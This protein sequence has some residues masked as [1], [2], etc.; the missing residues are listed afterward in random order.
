MLEFMYFTVKQFISVCLWNSSPRWWIRH[1]M[2]SV[3]KNWQTPIRVSLYKHIESQNCIRRKGFLETVPS[4][5]LNFEYLQGQ[6]SHSSG[7]SPSCNDLSKMMERDLTMT[8]NSSMSTLGCF[9][10]GPMDLC[11]FNWLKSF[12]S[13]SS[14]EFHS[15]RLYR[16]RKKMF[17]HYSF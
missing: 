13:T 9:P 14:F 11:T 6:I 5:S 3:L 2:W 1:T 10:S 8:S 4:K 15:H 17:L 16:E 7:T 12:L